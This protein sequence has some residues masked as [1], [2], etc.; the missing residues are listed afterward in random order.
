MD[1]SLSEMLWLVSALGVMIATI[2]TIVRSKDRR[3]SASSP[4]GSTY[5][6]GGADGGSGDGCSGGD[7]GGDCGGGD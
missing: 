6:D 4:D 5:S 3:R 1:R 7:G 2:A